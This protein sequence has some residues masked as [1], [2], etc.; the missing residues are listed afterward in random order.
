MKRK[1]I[2]CLLVTGCMSLAPL[3]AQTTTTT[4]TTTKTKTTTK[5]RKSSGT[6]AASKERVYNDAARLASLLSDAQTT[7]TVNADVWK[8]VANEAN[9][10][11]NRLYGETGG[12]ATARKAAKSTRDEVRQFRDAAL[13]GDAAGARDHANTALTSV[14]QLIEWASP[15]TT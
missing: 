4:T 12:N 10:L 7:V 5:A 8:T 11:A 15:K 6:S 2:L 1:S 3:F 13:A 9:S 14:W